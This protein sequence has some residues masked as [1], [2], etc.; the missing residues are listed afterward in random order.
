MIGILVTGHGRFASG[1]TSGI[2]LLAGVPEYYEAVDF[3][4][5]DSLE[6]LE[7]HI[8]EALDRLKGCDG[9]AIFTDLTGGSPFNVSS[10]I[11]RMYPDHRLEVTGGTNLPVV[12]NAY[13][14]RAVMSDLTELVEASLEAG[15]A[16]MVR[17]VI[18]EHTGNDSDDDE[19]EYED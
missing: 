19:I 9:V 12:L 10:K 2:E 5:E 4:P 11:K 18:E 14:S 13:M 15:K 16:Q 3:A 17:L 8:M 7:A 1:L 6:Q